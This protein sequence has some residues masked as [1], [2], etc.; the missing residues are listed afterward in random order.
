MVRS[1]FKTNVDGDVSSFYYIFSVMKFELKYDV[2]FIY[3]D[4]VSGIRCDFNYIS[5]VPIDDVKFEYSGSIFKV[6]N[7]KDNNSNYSVFDEIHFKKFLV[8][9]AENQIDKRM[10]SRNSFDHFGGYKRYFSLVDFELFD[11]EMNDLDYAFSKHSGKVDR[12]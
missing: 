9:D 11:K 10:F 1:V 7:K 8:L 4:I 6:K 3:S 2:D 5:K 12:G